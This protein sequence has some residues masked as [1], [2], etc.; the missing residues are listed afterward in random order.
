LLGATTS[1]LTQYRIDLTLDFIFDGEI[2]VVKICPHHKSWERTIQIK[3]AWSFYLSEYIG[4]STGIMQRLKVFTP[5][6]E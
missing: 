2:K 3:I 6:S 5:Y 4:D 1:T